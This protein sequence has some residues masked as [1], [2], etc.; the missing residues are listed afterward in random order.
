MKKYGKKIKD[1]RRNK[2]SI[3]QI[4]LN[5]RKSKD[6]G[7]DTDGQSV[8]EKDISPENKVEIQNGKEENE[9]NESNGDD[10]DGIA[11]DAEDIVHTRSDNRS[12]TTATE[13]H[14]TKDNNEN[15]KF[16][17]EENNKSR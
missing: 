10:K 17:S 15:G 2:T 11:K 4:S 14:I 5:Q 3:I 8:K 12:R 6:S 13:Q 16:N 9:I 7:P 1:L